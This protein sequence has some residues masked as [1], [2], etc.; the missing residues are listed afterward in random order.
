[1]TTVQN[2]IIV[3]KSPAGDMHGIKT[4]NAISSGRKEGLII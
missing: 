2:S 4:W 3:G 1:M